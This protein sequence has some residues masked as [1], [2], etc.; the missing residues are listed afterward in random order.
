MLYSLQL[1][2]EN[3]APGL[4]EQYFGSKY[5][6]CFITERLLAGLG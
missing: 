2:Q 1:L 6:H 4:G 3:F 5:M